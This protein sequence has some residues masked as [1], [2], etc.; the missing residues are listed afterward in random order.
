MAF[1]SEILNDSGTTV[2][3]LKGALDEHAQMPSLAGL[4]EVYL[5]LEELSYINSVGV[6][7]WI[8]WVQEAVK[9]TKIILIKCP[10]LFVKNLSSIRG[11]IIK[12]VTIQS[13]YV[14]YYDDTYNERKNVLFIRDKHFMDDGTLHMPEVK[15]SNGELIEPDIIEQSY[16]SFLRLKHE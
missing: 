10:A 6:R 15:S 1:S 14:P 9:T 7:V 5:D 3:Q 13:F 4:A 12:N 2:V 16:F 8:R 11:M